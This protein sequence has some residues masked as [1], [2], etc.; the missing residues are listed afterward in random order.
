MSSN[1]PDLS[2]EQITQIIDYINKYRAKN[3]APPMN[4]N[5]SISYFSKQWSKYLLTNNLFKHSGTQLYGENLAMFQGYGTDII[6]LIKLSIDAWYNEI[7][8][9]NFNNPGFSE[10]TGHFTCLVWINSTEFGIG[11]SIDNTTQKAIICMNT[12]P[13]GNV[14]G[15]FQQNVLPIVSAPTPTPEPTPTPSPEPTPTP[16][17]TP[18]PEP[19]P[20]PTPT[21][22]PEPTPEPTPI[23]TPLPIPIP[24]PTT[25][26]IQ[27]ILIYLN[28][29]IFWVKIRKP[30]NFLILQINNVIN[31]LLSLHYPNISNII[32]SLQMVIF[33]IQ[34]R[35]PTSYIVNLL[36]NVISQISIYT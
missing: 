34:T 22:T 29:I 15:E 13:P 24:R 4:H 19:T 16:T 17:Q 5:N 28:N 27:Q 25:Q 36:N 12:S 26:Q 7:S 14:I 10:A 8:L 33:S 21:P 30:P 9:Y 31:M 35:H 23:P 1:T 3:Q 11:I 6:N 32:Y 18:E 2:T 20:T